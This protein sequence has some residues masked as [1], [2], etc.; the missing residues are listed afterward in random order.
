MYVCNLHQ[1]IRMS[2]FVKGHEVGRNDRRT[3]YTTQGNSI[4]SVY[5]V[6]QTMDKGIRRRSLGKTVNDRL[7][8]K[9]GRE[10]KIALIQ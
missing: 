1:Y 6:S 3:W 5:R 2:V 7:E 10:T 8:P 9:D 4:P